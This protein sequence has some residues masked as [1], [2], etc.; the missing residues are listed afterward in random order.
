MIRKPDDR[1][2]C[3]CFGFLPQPVPDD[4]GKL[5]EEVRQWAK[6]HVAPMD[7]SATDQWPAEAEPTPDDQPTLSSSDKGS[8]QP[9]AEPLRDCVTCPC[10]NDSFNQVAPCDPNCPTFQ[11]NRSLR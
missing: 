7:R 9:P 8:S 5:R 3:T 2:L 11:R 4:F 1:P 6:V 10:M